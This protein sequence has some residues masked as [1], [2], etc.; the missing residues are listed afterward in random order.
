[1]SQ[2]SSAAPGWVAD[3]PAFEAPLDAR[4][5]FVRRTYAHVAGA[6]V[7]LVAL[8][9]M[10]YATGASEGFLTWLM[11]LGRLGAFV[12]IGGQMVVGIAGNAL[13]HSRTS[14]VL[15]YGGFGLIVAL[16]TLLLAPIL[17]IAAREAPGVL[18]P[19]AILTI[20][21]FA[22]LSGFVLVT[23]KDFSFMG[24]IL[25]VVGLVMLGTIVCGAIFGFN[26]GIWFT[27]IGI[28]FGCGTI[29]YNTS[30]VLHQYRTDEH[31][32]AAIQ[33]FVSLAYLFF[34]ILR[35]LMQLRGRN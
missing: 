26:L 12:W 33:L 27:A 35:L 4:M 29:L 19:A 5:A 30:A 22:G 6:A 34:Q 7:M 18:A 10:L 28:L 14:K 31:V 24:S 2:Y 11:S 15:Q 3:V 21:A 23:K 20:V 16:W 32:P 1:M 8:S 25:A 17:F 13:A 9:Y